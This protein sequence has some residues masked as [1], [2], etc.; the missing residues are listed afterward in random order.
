MTQEIRRFYFDNDTEKNCIELYN[1]KTQEQM[2]ISREN[3]FPILEDNY[4]N[5]S[6]HI[7]FQVYLSVI[8]I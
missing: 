5:I 4:P 2:Q 1:L 8:P 6:I 3:V 7:G